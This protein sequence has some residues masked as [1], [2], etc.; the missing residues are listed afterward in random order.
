MEGKRKGTRWTRQEVK[1]NL[2]KD[3]KSGNARYKKKNQ[4]R[5]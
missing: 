1:R 3:E 5:R 2:A 4:K